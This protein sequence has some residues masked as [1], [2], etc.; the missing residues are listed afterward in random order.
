MD[1]CPHG[2]TLVAKEE[3]GERIGKGVSH[4]VNE[5]VRNKQGKGRIGKRNGAEGLKQKGKVRVEL[6][7]HEAPVGDVNKDDAGGVERNAETVL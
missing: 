6:W 2:D 3:L 7:R 5:D 4:C 1:V